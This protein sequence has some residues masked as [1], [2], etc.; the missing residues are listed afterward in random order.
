[1]ACIAELNTTDVVR[2]D[3]VEVGTER[4]RLVRCPIQTVAL[5]H[6]RIIARVTNPSTRRLPLSARRSRKAMAV[7]PGRS[8]ECQQMFSH[9]RRH[10]IFPL[11]NDLGT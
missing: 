11:T 5:Y 7:P 10:I 6:H 2:Y 3:I 9:G 1:M 4:E 8:Y